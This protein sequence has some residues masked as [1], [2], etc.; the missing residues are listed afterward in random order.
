MDGPHFDTL[1]RALGA[2]PPRRLLLRR[3]AMAGG[4]A[5]TGRSRTTRAKQRHNHKKPKKNAF[6]CLSVGKPCNGKNN[7]CCSGIC[8]GK[9]P[10]KGKKDTSN[11]VAHNVGGCQAGQ[12][13]EQG[14]QVT[15]GV[16]GVCVR[17]TGN[18]SFCALSGN[19]CGDCRKD[20]ECE[21]QLGPGAACIDAPG[22]GT[23]PAT[24][25]RFA[26][27]TTF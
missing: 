3:L 9:R 25:C 16:A 20:T 5:V 21:A 8:K 11:C 7:K 22:C 10:R 17:T 27:P 4:L 6:G 2:A 1:V 18:A 12:D 15:C 19:Q 23:D 26:D 14:V 13:A 24:I